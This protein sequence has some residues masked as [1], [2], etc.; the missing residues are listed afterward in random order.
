MCAV[1]LT[2]TLFLIGCR[3]GNDTMP[4]AVTLS[5]PASLVQPGSLPVKDVGKNATDPLVKTWVASVA[6]VKTGDWQ[7]RVASRSRDDDVEWQAR[8]GAMTPVAISPKVKVIAPNTQGESEPVSEP[9]IPD[10]IVGI[11]RKYSEQ[12]LN[13]QIRIKLLESQIAN[14]S[15]TAR[16]LLT[17]KLDK[18]QTEQQA[19]DA[20]CQ[21]EI[22]KAMGH[23]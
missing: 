16:E 1:V 14:S 12:S 9:A 5:L 22:K 3:R 15:G 11:N 4:R 21:A 2:M 10:V 20:A 8:L 18:A 23:G 19:L 6:S 13:C 7:A 17:K